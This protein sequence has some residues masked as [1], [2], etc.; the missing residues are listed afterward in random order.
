MPHPETGTR[1]VLTR[2]NLLR[3]AML[4]VPVG[5]ALG[6][7]T[8]AFG[9][10][11]AG[12][13]P[14][15]PD[16]SHW[17]DRTPLLTERFDWTT[18][19]APT[20]AA[21]GGA[22]TTAAQS[23]PNGKVLIR[24]APGTIAAGR[25]A[26]STATGVL[27]AIGATGRAH[28]ILVVPRD[29][30]GT[31]TA[32]GSA[33]TS[34][35]YAFVGVNGVTLAGFDFV[36]KQVLVRGC[37]DFALAWS[38]FDVLNV[39]AN[40]GADAADIQFVECVLP[41]VRSTGTENDRMAFRVADDNSIRRLTMSGCYVAP[42]YKAAG[43]SS[44]TDT[45]QTSRS[46]GTGG[47]QDLTFQD[48]IFF[49]SSSQVLQLADTS[50]VV[51]RRSAFLGGLRGVDRYPIASGLHTMTGQNT[52]WGSAAAVSLTDSL[53]LGSVN[54]GW[55][56]TSASGNVVAVASS[57]GLPAGYSAAP[58]YVDRTVPMGAA[59]YA[60]NAPM[61]DAARLRT[62]WAAL[63]SAG[64][65]AAAPAAPPAPTVQPTPTPTPTPTP[66]PAPTPTPTPTRRWWWGWGR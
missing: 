18:D 41:N 49:Q 29:G 45:L 48:C 30:W 55:Q 25:G 17:P 53:I 36:N 33:E 7:T 63:G 23:Y 9:A 2:R 56:I 1:I 5:L 43:S 50:G 32:A 4:A 16:G 35:G 19:V 28:R 64:A 12:G 13:R 10:T 54:R 24:V 58:S 22:I 26:G 15:G 57:S 34:D 14:Y 8:P 47:I 37:Q 27:Q 11:T 65:A 62:I 21:I 3:G 51:V 40:K 31:V 60:A 61:P 38:T 66:A 42:S 20:W 52:L 6:S 59:W 39:T 44:H 46:G